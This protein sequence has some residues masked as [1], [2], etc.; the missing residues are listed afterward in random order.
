[1]DLCVPSTMTDRQ[2][3]IDLVRKCLALATSPFEGEAQSARQKARELM[4]KWG[5]TD[6]DVRPPQKAPRPAPCPGCPNCQ[7][8]MRPGVWIQFS[9]ASGSSTTTANRD[10]IW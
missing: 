5:L 3:K 1:M 2:R 10:T 7:P 4:K 6:A 9:T 8:F